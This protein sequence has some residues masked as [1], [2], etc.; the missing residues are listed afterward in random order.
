MGSA[1]VSDRP[2]HV[3][4]LR[5]LQE[6]SFGYFVHEV[7]RASGLV[8]DKT[9]ED[10]PA[11]I[12][13]VGMAL[14]CYPVGVERGFIDRTEGAERTLTTLR[15]FAGSEQSAA[16][17]A[18]GYKGFYYH[19]LH[20]GSGK[21]AWNSE[22]SS[23]DTALFIAGALTAAEYFDAPSQEEA[24]IRSLAKML[25]ER[26]EW[27]W[28]LQG[29]KTI[30]HGW[31]P[32]P[33]AG[34]IPYR[35]EGYDEAL[36]L[37]I[38]ALGSPTHAIGSECY[39][40]W[41]LSY[42]WKTVY[43]I[44]YLYA[45]P[46]FI[47]QLSHV[48]IDFRAIQ[49]KYMRGKEIDYFENSRRA[50]Q[51]QQQYG[52]RNPLGMA[53]MGELCWGVTASDGP[54]P[55]TKIDA[56]IYLFHMPLFFFL[57]GLFVAAQVARA[58]ARGYLATRPK[59]ILLPLIVWSLLTATFRILA[60][61][62]LTAADIAHAPVDAGSIFWFLWALLGCQ[63]VAVAVLALP[64]P[65]A[66]T[67]AVLAAA[68]VAV[69]VLPVDYASL[70]YRTVE[71]LPF[72]LIG[73]LVPLTAIPVTRAAGLA[74][75]AVFVAAELALPAATVTIAHY[76]LALLATGGAIVAIAAAATAAPA[77]AA[78]RVLAHFGRHSMAIYLMHLFFIAVHLVLLKVGVTSV[79]LHLIVATGLGIAGPLLAA[80]I[81]TALHLQALIGGRL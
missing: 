58:G 59:A 24:E 79:L 26:I 10:W 64:R 45:G 16:V 47:H 67:I 60:G 17:D 31:R 55:T 29:G 70:A 71:N 78:A 34:F 9:E 28:M 44:D 51:V 54:G 6:H 32:E 12:A 25:Y 65:R 20:M 77:S 8:L 21:R 43:D 19:F 18:T 42:E 1:T 69:A 23:I 53:H 76:A 11:S 41:C 74:G 81:A 73:M 68:L 49:D 62:P 72:Y 50:T 38:L 33:D 48:W 13:A 66:A 46:L 5:H 15:F 2:E 27:D 35:W 7:N 40:A 22:L 63:L 39:D 30:C 57:S 75:A 52:I 3:E 14:T 61:Q 37:Y 56:A 36:V 80:R 4:L